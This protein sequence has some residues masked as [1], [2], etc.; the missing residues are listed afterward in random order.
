M[1]KH[2]A[3]AVYD[4]TLSYK[5]C[6]DFNLLCEELL[7]FT[8]KF[9]FQLECGTNSNTYN[10]ESID[11]YEE[12]MSD[13]DEF[14]DDEIDDEEFDEEDF[15]N[16]DNNIDFNIDNYKSLNTIQNMNDVSDESDDDYL[17]SF[18]EEDEEHYSCDSDSD[19]DISVDENG[20]YKHYQGKIS[21]QTRKRPHELFALLKANDYILQKA[22]FTPSSNNGLGEIFYERYVTKCDTRIAGPW[23]D[24]TYEKPKPIPFYLR[25]KKLYPF[26][27]SLLDRAKFN[28][29]M[30]R[31]SCVY[32]PKGNTGKSWCMNYAACV[33]RNAVII[34]PIMNS[35]LDL[36][37]SV[38]SQVKNK[39]DPEIL[40]LDIPRSMPKNKM[41]DMISFAEQAKLYVFDTRYQYSGRHWL[42]PVEI[43]IFT[44]VKFWE[45][46]GW[47]LLSSDRW[48]I[49]KIT[50]DK[51]LVLLNG[52][53]PEPINYPDE[54]DDKIRTLFDKY[55]EFIE[56]NKLYNK[57]YKLIMNYRDFC[58][59][60]NSDNVI[61]T[62]QPAFDSVDAD[63][64]WPT[65]N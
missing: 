41:N 29:S 36:N 8:K 25:N 47:G 13:D 55:I 32:C 26:Q 20:E 37:Q 33:N 9:C 53:E 16:N 35:F 34:P 31:I 61:I 30:R 57:L 24:R 14:D 43:I 28:K 18:D 38:L 46:N 17:S 21:L 39:P 12:Y 4:F 64:S 10:H 52:D 7:Q 65:F 42:N 45:K 48:T 50:E 19:S 6:S 1:S 58:E 44:N 5:Y 15:Y 56:N 27:K 54:Y 23:S 3:L 62:H 60:L 2:N 22:H 11:D 49:Y 63:C 59:N 40:F 51:R